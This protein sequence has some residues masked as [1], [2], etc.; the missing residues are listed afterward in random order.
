MT[1]DYVKIFSWCEMSYVHINKSCISYVDNIYVK[2]LFLVEILITVR[3]AVYSQSCDYLDWCRDSFKHQWLLAMFSF[4]SL[5]STCVLVA[6]A[7]FSLSFLSSERG[8]T[9]FTG[10]Q[11]RSV[12]L[13]WIKYCVTQAIICSLCY[14]LLCC[15]LYL[16]VSVCN[17]LKMHNNSTNVLYVM[18]IVCSKQWEVFL[19]D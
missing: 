18:Y 7:S 2:Y 5:Q 4:A 17:S 19:C 8:R 9:L 6:R 14:T 3:D 12:F 10:T 16:K 15:V 1:I 11:G 13:P